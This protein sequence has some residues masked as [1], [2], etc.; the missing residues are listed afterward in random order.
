MIY[1]KKKFNNFFK[2]GN[3]KLEERKIFKRNNNKQYNQ[4]KN[5]TKDHFLLTNAFNIAKLI[6]INN[7]NNDNNNQVIPENYYF[8]ENKTRYKVNIYNYQKTFGNIGNNHI[9][10]NE[11]EL[12]KTLLVKIDTKNIE[13]LLKE[14]ERM[15]NLQKKH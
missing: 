9:N 1:D 14:K 7:N 2:I 6:R 8:E 15:I 11:D 10:T 5:I 12:L 4:R 13:E 3:I